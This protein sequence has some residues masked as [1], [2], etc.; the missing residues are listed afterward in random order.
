M[1][2]FYFWSFVTSMTI[3]IGLGISLFFVSDIETKALFD[4]LSRLLTSFVLIVFTNLTLWIRDRNI[5][6]REYRRRIT[7]LLN[8]FG[9]TFQVVLYSIKNSTKFTTVGSKE[10]VKRF[11]IFS[12][13]LQRLYND[14]VYNDVSDYFALNHLLKMMVIE[15]KKII[16]TKTVLKE[17]ADYVF[18]GE[19]I[20]KFLVSTEDNTMIDKFL[21]KVQ[22]LQE[23]KIVEVAKEVYK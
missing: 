14:I 11:K 12:D 13:E 3:S 20:K 8:P 9:D 7:N 6:K 1:K 18:L 23:V 16:E 19:E 10:I 21:K 5:Q 15:T 17:D 22:P 4:I 2:K